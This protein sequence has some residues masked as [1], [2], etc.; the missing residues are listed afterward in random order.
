MFV[1]NLSTITNAVRTVNE[2]QRNTDQRLSVDVNLFGYDG[3]TPLHLAASS[4]E[5]EKEL[6]S[7]SDSATSSTE[8]GVL[9]ILLRH[10]DIKVDLQDNQGRT[11]LH[12]AVVQKNTHIIRALLKRGA[13]ILVSTIVVWIN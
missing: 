6:G 3:V 10:K 5:I 2:S 4:A 13:S 7:T 8:E 9:D 1:G 11:P 12:Y